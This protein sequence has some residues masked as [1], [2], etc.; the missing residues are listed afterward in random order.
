MINFL[1]IFIGPVESGHRIIRLV[2]FTNELKS[3]FFGNFHVIIFVMRRLDMPITAA[4][5]VV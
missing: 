3:I 1:K 2:V 5:I 4:V